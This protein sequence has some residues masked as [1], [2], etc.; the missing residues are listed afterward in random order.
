MVSE[1]GELVE[2]LQDKIERLEEENAKLK[3]VKKSNYHL[4]ELAP[5][6]GAEGPLTAANADLLLDG[7]P[8]K[9]CR[10]CIIQ[11]DAG[12]AAIVQLEFYA[13]VKFAAIGELKQIVV[14]IDVASPKS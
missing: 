6:K 4:V 3:N 2:R 5:K 13:A 14:P 10:R 9:G 7:E 12:G 11:L 8:V 1:T